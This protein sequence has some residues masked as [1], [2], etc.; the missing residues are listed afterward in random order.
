[1]SVQIFYHL[2]KSGLRFK[3]VCNFNSESKSLL[4]LI[5]YRY[6]KA[7]Q[8][9]FFGLMGIVCTSAPHILVFSG[10]QTPPNIPQKVF[11]GDKSDNTLLHSLLVKS[12]QKL[13]PDVNTSSSIEINFCSVTCKKSL[14]YHVV[15][16]HGNGGCS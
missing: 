10:Y 8:T 3:S 13:L 9:A 11:H 7:C 14:C 5:L 6:M 15:P 1:M 12:R 16:S 4:A 2:L